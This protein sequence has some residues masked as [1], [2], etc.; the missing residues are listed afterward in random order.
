MEKKEKLISDAARA[1]ELF[2]EDELEA[3]AQRKAKPYPSSVV[4]LYGKSDACQAWIQDNVHG[5]RD[6]GAPVEARYIQDIVDGL[7]GEGFEQGQD[8]EVQG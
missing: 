2:G 8:F 6:G 5:A 4:M 3:F 1:V 7:H